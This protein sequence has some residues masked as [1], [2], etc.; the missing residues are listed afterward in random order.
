M[1]TGGT[2]T[3]TGVSV[4]TVTL[5]VTPTGVSV[6]GS[7]GSGTITLYAIP[8]PGIRITGLLAITEPADKVAPAISGDIREPPG[9][10]EFLLCI[11]ARAK[12]IDALMGDLEEDF[13]RDRALGMSKRRAAARYW[14]RVLRSVGPQ[15]W[16]AIRRVGLLGLIAA[17]LRRG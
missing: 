3:L 12:D 2:V 10:A 9:V 14:A 5:T 8:E 17:A 7:P 1:L 13:A 4:D 16:Q 11:F 6:T 15:M